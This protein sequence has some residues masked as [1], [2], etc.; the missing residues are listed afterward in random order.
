MKAPT[1]RLPSQASGGSLGACNDWFSA[2]WLAFMAS[3]PNA[4]GNPRAADRTFQAQTWYRDPSA[5]KTTDLSD[6]L[7]FILTP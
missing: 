4:I 2:D 5:L 1:Q 6:G 3:I 7:E